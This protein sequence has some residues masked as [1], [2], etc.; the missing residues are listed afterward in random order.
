MGFPGLSDGLPNFQAF[1]CMR[2]GT[3][4]RAQVAG[5]EEEEQEEE[6]EGKGIVAQDMFGIKEVEQ[7]QDREQGIIG[8]KKGNYY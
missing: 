1:R 6:E 7:L 8:L 2:T 4:R 3:T 5:A